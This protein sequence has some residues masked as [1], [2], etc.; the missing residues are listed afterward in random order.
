MK[1]EKRESPNLDLK[2]WCDRCSIRIA[3][4]EERAMV[5]NKAYHAQCYAKL[6]PAHSK[7]KT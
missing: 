1:A 5:G 7:P 4:S 6:V 3:P 2:V